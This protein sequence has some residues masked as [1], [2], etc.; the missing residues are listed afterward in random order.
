MEGPVWNSKTQELY[1]VDILNQ[2]LHIF[3]PDTQENRALKVPS[4][5]G[6][7]G[8]LTARDKLFVALER[9]YL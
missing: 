1:W 2:E 6:N 4:R 9:R 8:C 3:S 7:R 5:I